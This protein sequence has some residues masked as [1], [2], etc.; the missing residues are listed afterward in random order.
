MFS[1]L[2]EIARP[3]LVPIADMLKVFVN[4]LGKQVLQKEPSSKPCTL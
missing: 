2:G 1:V 3:V 4:L